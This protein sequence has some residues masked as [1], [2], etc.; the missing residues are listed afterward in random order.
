MKRYIEHCP[1]CLEHRIRRYR[2][3]GSLQ[4]ILYLAIPFHTVTI[5]IVLA[6]PLSNDEFDA[7]LTMT[8][9]YTK[10]M[11]IIPG[12]NTW[13]GED[14]ARGVL[15]FWWTANWGIPTVLLTDR[16]PKFTQGLWKAIFKLICTNVLYTTSYHPQTDGQSER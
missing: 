11:G 16:D 12:C 14:W 1:T 2:P 10:L 4:P 8:D 7:A 15:G 3:Y 9:K 5:D 13:E 6:I